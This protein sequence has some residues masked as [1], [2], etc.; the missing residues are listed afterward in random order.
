MNSGPALRFAARMAGSTDPQGLEDMTIS[1]L[2]GEQGE[3]KDELDK[4]IDWIEDHCQA[5]VIHL[6]NALLLGLVKRIKERLDVMV[7]CSLQDE[8]EWVDAMEERFRSKT[9]H[10]MSE[11]AEDVDLFISVSEYYAT[12]MKSVLKIPDSK[13]ITQHITIDPKDYADTTGRPLNIGYISRMCETNGLEILVEAFILLRKDPKW[14]DVNLVITGGSTGADDDFIKRIKKKIKNA[15][16]Q[17]AVDFH[18]DFVQEGRTEFF[19]KV[20]LLSVPASEGTAFGLFL[21]E[22]MASGVPV[23]Q[24]SIGAFPEI[25]EKA[26]GG[27]VYNDNTPE[28]L[29]NAL[30][31]LLSDPEHLS[32]LSRKGRAGVSEEFSIHN[33]TREIIEVYKRRINE[34]NMDTNVT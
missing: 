12:K 16:L 10:L 2:L 25:I 34:P 9:W 15:G 6:S 21:L 23:V 27:V 1:M 7:V 18:K 29:A 26:G 17:E 11:R 4:L 13:L 28:C 14:S 33:Q 30:S 8:D 24:P 19:S 32:V 3:Q 20:A 22:S 31:G 5:D